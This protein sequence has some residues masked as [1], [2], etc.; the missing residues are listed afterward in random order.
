MGGIMTAGE[1]VTILL[2]AAC[3]I[4]IAQVFSGC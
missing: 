4:G 3:L 2:A 1:W